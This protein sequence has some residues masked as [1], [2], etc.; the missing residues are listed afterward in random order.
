MNYKVCLFIISCLYFIQYLEGGGKLLWN[1][2][3][4]NEKWNGIPYIQ[5][6]SPTVVV[7]SIGDSKKVRKFNFSSHGTPDWI[8]NGGESIC[9]SR[10]GDTIAVA[11]R[12]PST[13]S[14]ISLLNHDSNE[15]IWEY[16]MGNPSNNVQA[17]TTP[18]GKKLFLVGASALIATNIWIF[19]NNFQFPYLVVVLPP[20]SST[21]KVTLQPKNDIGVV[22]I[23]FE[24][25]WIVYDLVRDRAIYTVKVDDANVKLSE[26]GN[27]F[28]IV[29]DN[30]NIWMYNPSTFSY[31][32]FKTI[33]G[34][35]GADTYYAADFAFSP[36]SD[37][38]SV[39]WT[40]EKNQELNH[41]FAIQ[42]YT[43]SQDIRLLWQ[44]QRNVL[45]IPIFPTALTLNDDG[46]LLAVG[47]GTSTSFKVNSS[48]IIVFSQKNNV[49]IF[50]E[51]LDLY[52]VFGCEI[53]KISD[54]NFLAVTTYSM[55]DS[56]GMLYFIQL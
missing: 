45:E 23:Y 29:T 33:A 25:W 30:I 21:C 2:K 14:N 27:Y 13:I 39:S 47:L 42:Y 50:E 20:C 35:F 15:S 46:S 3:I 12:L 51:K 53:A 32:L 52:S 37:S 9:L 7:L 26:N 31:T 18:D 34:K 49:P 41:N 44:F 6:D 36:T 4:T 11:D 54:L 19:N 1:S 40:K 24:G 48:N 8:F 38:F 17:V 16:R 10:Y 5:R 55:D 43:L 28:A 56:M 22:G